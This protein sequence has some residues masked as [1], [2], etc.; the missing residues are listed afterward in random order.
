MD[1]LIIGAFLTKSLYFTPKKIYKNFIISNIQ[2][3]VK[4]SPIERFVLIK[5]LLK[6]Y[7]WEGASP[8]A[9]WLSSHVLLI[10]SLGFTGSDPRCGH[11]T[12]W[13]AMLW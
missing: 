7:R 12:A 11:G 3:I 9:Q 10:G 2:S 8:V 6:N 4:L 13:H 5:M 1:L